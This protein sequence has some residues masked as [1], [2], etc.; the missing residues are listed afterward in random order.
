MI[1]NIKK[2][3]ITRLDITEISRI[4]IQN[5]F[6]IFFFTL[7]GLITGYFVI[8]QE[9]SEKKFEIKIALQ[10]HHYETIQKLNSI[11][12]STRRIAALEREKQ[13]IEY[14]KIAEPKLPIITN[15]LEKDIDTLKI[16][17]DDV[18]DIILEHT[19]ESKLYDRTISAYNNKVLSDFSSERDQNKFLIK[20]KP[21]YLS[22]KEEI[23]GKRQITIRIFFSE[24]YSEYTIDNFTSIYLE[25]IVDYASGVIQNKLKNIFDN[26]QLDRDW[27]FNL[28][29]FSLQD[30][31]QYKDF[32]VETYPKF[33]TKDEYL[34][35]IKKTGILDKN[36]DFFYE[37]S[38]LKNNYKKHY[39]SRLILQ[40]NNSIISFAIL[41]FI[42]GLIITF[43]K[44]RFTKKSI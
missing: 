16:T 40:N 11:N 1:F 20:N 29:I 24:N 41:G 2:E 3:N 37:S 14:L 35:E 32:F 27:L 39:T 23:N 4:I 15:M 43:I 17:S 31:E 22:L 28:V 10:E 38:N 8:N 12:D 13:F 18:S 9:T 7:V 42:I 5:I 30:H 19:K 34:K 6:V 26:F 36:F 25:N 44:S 33:N 21:T